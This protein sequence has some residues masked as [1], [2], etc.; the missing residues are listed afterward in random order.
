LWN[1]DLFKEMPAAARGGLRHGLR[2][3]WTQSLFDQQHNESQM[4]VARP[5]AIRP[6]NS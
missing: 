1:D 2:H 5:E 4:S 6:T 3:G